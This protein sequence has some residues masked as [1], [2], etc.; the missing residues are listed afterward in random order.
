MRRLCG[1]FSETIRVASLSSAQPP[2]ITDFG[3]LN[4][5]NVLEGAP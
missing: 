3:E 2:V 5:I 1:R 4:D